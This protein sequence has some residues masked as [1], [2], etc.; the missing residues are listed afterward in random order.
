MTEHETS[1]LKQLSGDVCELNGLL[2]DHITRSE[3]IERAV[4]KHE[5]DL[6]GIPGD[7]EKIGISGR[8]I[9]VE[10]QAESKDSEIKWH[11]HVAWT[12]FTFLASTITAL[13]MHFWK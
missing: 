8:L 2:R 1:I 10:Q 11:V 5:A 7:S 6:Y 3:P 13:V 9:Q 12:G 4:A